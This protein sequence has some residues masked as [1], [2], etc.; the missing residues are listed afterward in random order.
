[1]AL[2][3]RPLCY[4]SAEY[5]RQQTLLLSVTRSED[6]NM[7]FVAFKLPPMFT[8]LPDSPHI[9]YIFLNI[10]VSNTNTIVQLVGSAY[11]DP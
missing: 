8:F 10:N 6:Q 9:R 1:M 7:L 5:K 3:D 2:I 11:R 4:S